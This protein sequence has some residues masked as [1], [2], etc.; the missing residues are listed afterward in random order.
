MVM[1]KVIKIDPSRPNEKLIR[2]AAE[3]IKRGGLVAFPTETVYGLGA[4]AFNR[5]AVLKI[6][7]VKGRPP[8]NPLIIHIC[9]FNQ[10]Y[11]L[12]MEVPDRVI[13]IVKKFWPGPLTVIL[14]KSS[15]VI[16]EVTASL[17]T[18]AI[19]M[20]AHPIA[21]KLIEYSS[22]PI[23]AP[24]ANLS[25]RPSPTTPQHVINDLMGLIDVIID[26][27]ETLFGVES[28]IIDM[29]HDP[30]RLLRPG[31]LTIE[32]V[33]RV[34]GGEVVIPPFARGLMESDKALSPGVKYRH[35]APKAR[36]VLV[37]L[38]SYE[39]LRPLIMKVRE[40][41][42]MYVNEGLRVGILCSDETISHYK[43]IR[44]LSLSLGPRSNQFIIAKNLFKTLRAFDEE[45]V[46]IIVAEGFEERGLGLTI[47]NR[48]R[49]ASGYNIVK[50][51]VG[52]L[53]ICTRRNHIQAQ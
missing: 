8:D 33:E 53:A 13:L 30:P 20:P 29:T 35:Y 23:A 32:E 17:P 7:K 31:P 28:T 12:A 52:N 1:T 9:R 38:S 43:D 4:D 49:K 11:E 15:R 2:E 25:G 37:E 41:A 27:G 21:L 16:N 24:S 50:V 47:M 18:V 10:L 6:F 51:D 14:R 3:V 40:L 36:M 19:R 48:L 45:E 34:L 26:G 44:A 39:D 46:D 22:T 42:L 5:L